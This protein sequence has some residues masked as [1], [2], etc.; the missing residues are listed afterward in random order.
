[1]RTV[2]RLLT[3]PAVLPAALVLTLGLTACSSTTSQSAA[4][5][6]P[7]PAGTTTASVSVQNC[8]R[9]VT[10]PHPAER[11]VSGWVT[12]TELLLQ[13]GDS[14][15]L[16]GQYN[17]SSGTPSAQYADA[18]AKVPVLST[19]GLTR[20]QLAAAHPDLVWADGEY[21]FDGNTLPTIDQLA[22]QGTQVLVLSGFCG[23]DA[24][25]AKVSDVF[26]DLAAIGTLLGRQTATDELAEQLHTRLDAVSQRIAGDPAVPVMFLANYDGTLYTYDGVYTDIA[27]LAGGSNVYA[28]QLPKGQYYSEVSRED[29]IARDPSTIVLLTG[30]DGDT[31]GAKDSLSQLLPGVSAVRDGKVV[32]MPESDSTNLRAVDGV[33]ELSEALHP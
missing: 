7:A 25:G 29:V 23:D 6:A 3:L 4:G 13:L 17:T 8:G 9:T 10:L 2:P 28:G 16:V 15:E 1:M 32:T 27:E 31:V 30:G 5:R 19:E 33:E 14:D 24:T 11:V 26:T 21:A 22:D 20:E 12:S 18:F